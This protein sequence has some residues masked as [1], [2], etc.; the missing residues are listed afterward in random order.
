MKL[1]KDKCKNT[2]FRKNSTN[3]DRKSMK[4][5]IN[6]GL[7]RAL[8]DMTAASPPVLLNMIIVQ[9]K[10]SLGKICLKSEGRNFMKVTRVSST[11]PYYFEDTYL[12]V[13]KQ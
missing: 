4:H 2:K 6:K 1:F 13:S 8:Q 3:L 10:S 7:H 5:K 9:Q 11:V 12:F